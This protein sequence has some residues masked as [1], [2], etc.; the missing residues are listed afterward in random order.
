MIEDPISK[1]ILRWFRSAHSLKNDHFRKNL[2]YLG[3][4]L[5]PLN[6]HLCVVFTSTV[7]SIVSPATPNGF[8]HPYWV[9]HRL[10]LSGPNMSRL[11][12]RPYR[13]MGYDTQKCKTSMSKTRT[14]RNDFQD[15]AGRKRF[16]SID[17]SQDKTVQQ[18]TLTRTKTAQLH[19]NSQRFQTQTNSFAQSYLFFKLLGTSINDSDHPNTVTS[20]WHGKK[21]RAWNTNLPTMPTMPTFPVFLGPRTFKQV[22]ELRFRTSTPRFSGHTMRPRT[23]SKLRAGMDF[24]EAS[25]CTVKS[26]LNS[27]TDLCPLQKK[28]WLFEALRCL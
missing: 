9:T 20:T 25:P 23:T 11:G 13:L 16:M 18:K 19:D 28:S 14:P 12:N 15:V 6:S 2:C 7:A 24:A 4:P 17:S 26:W 8:G 22:H 10:C 5:Y 3:H 21:K 1:L 27:W